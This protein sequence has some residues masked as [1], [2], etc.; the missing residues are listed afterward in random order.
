MQNDHRIEVLEVSKQHC[1]ISK[2]IGQKLTIPKEGVAQLQSLVPDLAP[3]VPIQSDLAGSGDQ[4]ET[5]AAN[6]TL[7]VHLGP[8]DEGFV[9][10][11]LV[12]PIDK[13]GKLFHPG[14]GGEHI[15]VE[16][17]NI[18]VQ[19]ER[20][21]Q[22]ERKYYR[23]VLASSVTI[24][25]ME[26][27][28]FRFYAAG[29]Q[30]CLELLDALKSCDRKKVNV[31][32][33]EGEKLRLSRQLNI[34]K[35]SF[36]IKK[37]GTDW[38]EVGGG[39]QIDDKTMMNMAE[40]LE[41]VSQSSSRF[42]DMGD[43]VFLALEQSLFRQLKQLSGISEAG[44][45][46]ALASSIL[47]EIGNNAGQ[48][49]SSKYWRD[50]HDRWERSFEKATPLPSTLQ[51]DLRDYQHIGFNWLARLSDLNIGACLA[52]D[53]GLG[54]T[55]QALAV[56]LLRAQNGPALVVAPVS[57]VP[58]WISEIA[59]FAP[60]L[61]VVWMIG[62]ASKRKKLLEN[63]QPFDVVICS[64][65]VLAPDQQNLSK[66]AWDMVVLDEAQAIKNHTTKRAS[67]AFSLDAKFKLVTTGTPM[68][69]H[70]GELWSIF[71][72][73]TPGYLGSY[74]KFNQ[75]FITPIEGNT[76][77]IAKHHLKS[78]IQPF[79]LR[80][81][82]S[83]VLEE[84][85]PKTEITLNVEMSE[86]ERAFY[87]TLRRQAVENIAVA[88]EDNQPSH[89]KILAEIMRLRRCCC[90][91]KLI[92]EKITI[93]SSKLEQ[94][95]N[96]LMELR[97]GDHKVL[98]FSQFVGHLKIIREWLDATDISYQYLDGSTP[99]KRRQEAVRDFQNGEGDC[100][101]ISLKAGGS[102]LNLTAA[103]YVIHMDPWWNPAVEDQA[104][105][106]AHRIGQKQPV[107][108]YRL[109]VSDSIEEKIIALHKTK[110]DLADSLLEGTD[111]TGRISA[112]ELIALLTG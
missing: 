26:E 30:Q 89:V 34:S 15:L 68:E 11:F 51:A 19:T 84:L 65:G 41:H 100:F 79:M 33:P 45:V 95:K 98:I 108:I 75:R 67:A 27:E 64:Y 8:V 31:K 44:K 28:P 106:R 77:G 105:D 87:E 70:L 20:N 72:F 52:D 10:E 12:E 66:V 14:K 56:M 39:V 82:K 58:N 5:V 22:K 9:A 21:L 88:A 29:P 102:G 4:L 48:F 110:R 37:S 53:M 35:L 6:S 3:L 63:L 16:L 93:D 74:D 50:H 94:L 24:Q 1:D 107:T 17:G 109:V 76:D 69:N 103:S 78:L 23:D 57:V 61:N 85:P 25:D 46:H 43:E 99:V 42:L 97:A 90:H 59:K 71:R 47:A 32:W 81:K 60:T 7:Q 73:I 92:D 18:K 83:Q 91:P 49:K 86:Q 80:R 36:D 38:F 40:L 111:Q 62:S 104:S 96:L 54:K 2:K 112:K 55:I 13:S 101:L